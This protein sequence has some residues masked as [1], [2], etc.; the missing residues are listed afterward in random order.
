MTTNKLLMIMLFM[1]KLNL[2]S[3]ELSMIFYTSSVHPGFFVY[4]NLADY[5][6]AFQNAELVS[7]LFKY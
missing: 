1:S 7:I 2:W 3:Q 5:L 4:G 6:Q